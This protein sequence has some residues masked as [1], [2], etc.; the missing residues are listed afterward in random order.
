MAQ[1]L[2]V[3]LDHRKD[4]PSGHKCRYV[5]RRPVN[6]AVMS[7]AYLQTVIAAILEGGPHPQT[8]TIFIYG[9]EHARPPE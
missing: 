9:G 7:D 2:R 1:G 8:V 4:T 5:A 3:V 6:K